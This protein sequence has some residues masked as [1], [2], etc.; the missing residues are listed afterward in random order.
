MKVLVVD[1]TESNRQLLSWILE[2]AGHDPL[3]AEDGSK[4]V[5][6]FQEESVDL[7]LMDVMM[8]VMDGYEAATSI[9]AISEKHVPIIFL[10]ALSEQEALTKSLSA[11]GDDFITKPINEQILKSKMEAHE[12]VIDLTHE[13]TKKNHE[14]ELY[15]SHTEQEKEVAEFVLNNAMRYNFLRSNNTSYSLSP[16]TTFNGDILLGSPSPSGG[17]F[18]LMGDFTGHGLAA[19]IGSLPLSRVFFDQ[20]SKG[21]SVGDIVRAINAELLDFLPDTMFCALTLLEQNQSG[22]QINIWTGGLPDA[23]IFDA[24]GQLKHRVTSRHMPLGVLMDHEFER[25]IDVINLQAG[26]EILIF[27]DGVTEAC[28]SKGEMFGEERLLS[29]IEEQGQCDLPTFIE[30][31]KAFSEDISQEDDISLVKITAEPIK[32]DKHELATPNH[33]DGSLPWQL[34]IDMNAEDLKG[35]DPIA[36]VIDMLGS[37]D[38]L[39]AHKDYLYTIFS[40]LFSNALEHG[41]LDL[42]SELKDTDEGYLKYYEEREERLQSLTNASLSID[43]KL[44]PSS[45]GIIVNVIFKNSGPGFDISKINK[46]TDDDSYGRGLGLLRTLCQD[47]SYIDDG[48]QVIA[49][50]HAMNSGPI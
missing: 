38:A 48:R 15:R 27:S 41:I 10:T 32:I 36:D 45:T 1:D 5:E 37:V 25:D 29:F 34:H 7:I 12:R 42:K 2:D 47:L 6:L 3:C 13:L 24:K 40:E 4:A 16:A 19:S 30:H 28:N 31:H 44:E 21:N 18:I 9:K 35:G 49:S 14:L 23:L 26:D 39:V 43:V 20:T 22:N 17:Q 11:G 46:V 8:P 50:Y 33:K